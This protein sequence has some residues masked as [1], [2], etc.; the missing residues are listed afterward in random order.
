VL[1]DVVTMLGHDHPLYV[2]VL[3]PTP[4]VV[5][6]REAGRVKTGYTTWTPADLDH[7][8]RTNTPK[9]G[10]WLDTSA[11]SVD[12]T[13]GTIRARLDEARIQE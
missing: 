1:N 11:L 6:Q 10:L 7:E 8:L 13:V 2:V 12:K 5:A 4:E 9:I 3:C